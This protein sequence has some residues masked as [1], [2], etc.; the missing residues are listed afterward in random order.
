MPPR[1]SHAP[2]AACPEEQLERGELLFYPQCPFPMPA[3]DDLAFLLAQRVR[4]FSAKNIRFDPQAEKVAGQLRQGAEPAARLQELLSNFSRSVTAWLLDAFPRYGSGCTPVRATFCPEE[5]ATLASRLQ[6]RNDLLHIDA[7]RD[8]PT[9]GRRLLRVF[10]N[11]NPH[12]PRVLG[13]R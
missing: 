4:P 13:D 2:P 3:G 8:R 10:V 1:D 5:E 12:D 9:N 11:V 7:F 6:A